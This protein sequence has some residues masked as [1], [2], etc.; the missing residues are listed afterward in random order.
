MYSQGEEEI[1][2]GV[3]PNAAVFSDLYKAVSA[4]PYFDGDE[5]GVFHPLYHQVLKMRGN[6]MID[7]FAQNNT[8]IRIDPSTQSINNFANHLKNHVSAI[9]SWVNG[10]VE[11]YSKGSL[12]AKFGKGAKIEING[13]TTLVVN[14][15]LDAKVKEN[16]TIAVGK[17]VSVKGRNIDM[18]AEQTLHLD[19]SKI[20]I[21]LDKADD[22]NAARYHDYYT[23]DENGRRVKRRGVTE[24][25]KVWMG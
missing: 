12:T 13:D 23:L 8:G 11:I 7:L 16:A 15:N 1:V 21:G 9:T 18:V 5:Q 20:L 10:D 3:N 4:K 22:H 17:S 2:V 25:N 19:G 6:K 14:G 24:S